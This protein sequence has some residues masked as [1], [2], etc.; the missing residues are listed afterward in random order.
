M[1]NRTSFVI[2]HRIQTILDADL[3][4]VLEDGRTVQRGTHDELVSREGIYRQI[5]NIQTRIEAELQEEISNA[6]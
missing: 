1:E 3:I 4:L 5:F 2:A 6:V